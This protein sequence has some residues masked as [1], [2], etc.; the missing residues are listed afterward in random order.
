MESVTRKRELR[1]KQVASSLGSIFV[2]HVSLVTFTSN[3]ENVDSLLRCS[4]YMPFYNI[5][6]KYSHDGSET[7]TWLHCEKRPC[8]E[9]SFAEYVHSCYI[10]DRM[11]GLIIS[12][13]RHSAPWY[14]RQHAR[15]TLLDRFQRACVCVC[16]YMYM[17][18]G[19]KGRREDRRVNESTA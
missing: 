5:Y 12:N 17:I 9:F 10:Y 16:V 19:T 3:V 2:S 15:V 7:N 18:K 14:Q 4:T 13:L 11:H 6:I 1:R 8:L